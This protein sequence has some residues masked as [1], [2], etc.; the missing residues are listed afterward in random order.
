LQ[1]THVSPEEMQKRIA[2]FEELQEWNVMRGNEMPVEVR[3][4]VYARKLVSAVVP[5]GIEGPFDN[6]TAI[7]GVDNFSLTYAMCPPGQG[8]GLHAHCRTTE[9][10]TCIQGTFRVLWGDRGEH[11]V[12]LDRLDSIS[13]PP[14]VVREFRNI[15]D[16]EGILQ[17]LITGGV[18]DMN[19]IALAPSLAKQ[20]AAHGHEHLATFEAMGMTFDAGPDG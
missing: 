9:T 6:P 7:H 19:D 11:S 17:V 4:L 16:G 13:I 5:E 1:T 10:F 2:R 8:P 20:I 15:G 3:D 14:G 18:H 12:D